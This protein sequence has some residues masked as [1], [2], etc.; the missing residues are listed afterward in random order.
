VIN[1]YSNGTAA[2]GIPGI[3]KPGSNIYKTSFGPCIRVG[4]FKLVGGRPGGDDGVIAWPEWSKSPVQFGLTSGSVEPGTDHHRAGGVKPPQIPPTIC[5]PWC[6]F[7]LEKV[8]VC[9]CV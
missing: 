8:G 4:N 2:G 3:P 1:A 6:L 7:D 5:S 9:V